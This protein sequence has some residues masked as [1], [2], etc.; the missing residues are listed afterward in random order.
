MARK[1]KG[2]THSKADARKARKRAEAE[3]R[4]TK[5]DKLSRVD[6][7]ALATNRGGSQRELDRLTRPKESQSVSTPAPQ[8]EVVAVTE[9]K[10]STRTSKSKIVRQA[11]SERPSRS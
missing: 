1:E 8:V 9:A 5:Y 2:Y 7:I 10:K 6:K 11:K 3:A 4:Q